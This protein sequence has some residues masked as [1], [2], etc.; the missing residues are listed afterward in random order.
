[1]PS[2]SSPGRHGGAGRLPKPSRS[3]SR[4]RDGRVVVTAPGTATS[5]SSTMRR[6]SRLAVR[7][8]LC[9]R[10]LTRPGLFVVCS[11]PDP[12]R[13]SRARTRTRTSGLRSGD[14]VIVGRCGPPRTTSSS[15]SAS[16]SRSRCARCHRRSTIRSR[17]CRPWTGWAPRWPAWPRRSG[18]RAIDMTMPARCA[19]VAA[20]PDVRRR[21][22]HDLQ[23]DPPLRWDQPGRPE[24]PARG[25]RGLRPARPRRGRLA[26]CGTRPRRCSASGAS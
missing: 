12:G 10:I 1:M 23:P 3:R 17:P 8:D 13:A 19:V 7:H 16:S 20:G 4:T 22:P 2:T 15:A 5:R 18:R 25:G 26:S 11:E 6:C 14:T 24:P 21:H 9:I